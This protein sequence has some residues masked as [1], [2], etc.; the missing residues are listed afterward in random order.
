MIPGRN[1]STRLEEMTEVIGSPDSF[2]SST[3]CSGRSRFVRLK[4]ATNLVFECPNIL[5]KNRSILST[6][7]WEK[8]DPSCLQIYMITEPVPPLLVRYNK[9]VVH[10]LW[11]C[12]G[13][14]GNGL[15]NFF[16]KNYWVHHNIWRNK[17]LKCAPAA[18]DQD[19]IP[20]NYM[21]R[22]VKTH[23]CHETDKRSTT[24]HT[25]FVKR[26]SWVMTGSVCWQFEM[27]CSWPGKPTLGP[28]I[29]LLCQ[30]RKATKNR[31]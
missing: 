25:R 26:K 5:K 13:W 20:N 3:H 2:T 12:L 15:G 30:E 1:E 9:E 19:Q 24:T 21:Q 4:A 11:D 16:L 29:V 28:F 14:Y 17:N 18:R 27:L 8:S 22:I 23:R 10:R 7:R 31:S 6:Q